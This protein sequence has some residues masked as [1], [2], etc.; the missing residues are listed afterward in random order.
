MF[1]S[2][3]KFEFFSLPQ[4]VGYAAL[5]ISCIAFSQTRDRHLRGWMMA[6][7]AVYAVHFF[8]LGNLPSTAGS[9][10]NAVRNGLSLF[11]RS[12]W[13][14]GLMVGAS[15]AASFILAAQAW[16][17][18]PLIASA[19]AT[20]AVFRLAGMLLRA[21]LMCCSVLWLINNYLVGSIGGIAIEIVAIGLNLTTLIRLLREAK[22]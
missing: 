17:I 1:E 13:A 6:Q 7:N 21:T 14:V 16:Q 5:L 19:L 12:W 15:I 18:L 2:F 9:S 10:I 20:V 4:W 3:D 11:T 8:L 22:K